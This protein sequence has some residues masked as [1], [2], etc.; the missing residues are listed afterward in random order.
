MLTLLI[1]HTACKLLLAA[2]LGGIIGLERELHGK[3]AGLRTN[4]LIA[5]GSAL[6]TTISIN[7]SERLPENCHR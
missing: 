6:F 7:E 2:F 1:T 3:P 4:M 5:M